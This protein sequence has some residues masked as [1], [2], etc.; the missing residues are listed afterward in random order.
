[1]HVYPWRWLVSI[2][3]VTGLLFLI[4]A[5]C[6]PVREDRSINW[7]SGGESVGFQHGQE[8][9]FIADKDTGKLIKVFQPDP[10]VLATSSPL[11][12]PVGRQLLFT[13]ARDPKGQPAVDVG[14]LQGENPAGNIYHQRD[15]IY[16]CWLCEEA[17]AEKATKPIALFEAACDHV[18]YVAANLVVRWHPQGQRILYIKQTGE[19]QHGLFE[20]DLE[21]KQSRQVLPHSSQDLIFDWTPDGTH[22]V[23]VLGSAKEPQETDGI[24]I[25]RPGDDDWWQVPNSGQFAKAELSSVLEQLRATR[26]AWTADGTRFAFA[27]YVP[28]MTKEEPGRHT[29][30]FG[31]LANQQ[32]EELV[33][34]DQPYRELH[35]SPDNKQLGMLRGEQ[36]AALHLLP[37]G[38]PLSQPINN[39]PVRRFAG[40]NKDGSH[41]AY[42]VPDGS[43][44]DEDDMWAFLLVPDI[45][46]RDA[47]YITD[48]TG[49]TPG[50]QVFSGLRVTFPQWSPKDDK[51]SLWVTFSPAYRSLVSHLLGWGLRRGDPAAIFDLKTREMSWMAVNAQEKIQIGHYHLLKH[52]YA[53]AWRWYEE[54]ERELPP[55]K[56]ATPREFLEALQSLSGPRDFSFFQYHCLTKLER[57]DDA[58]RKLE[59]FQ[60]NF[61]PKLPEA[62]PQ[63]G[64]TKQSSAPAQEEI[65]TE[66][67]MRELLDPSG[68]FSQLLRD[69]YMAEVFLS[70]DAAADGEAFFRQS[71]AAADTDQARLSHALVLGEMLLLQKKHAAYAELATDKITP[72][73]FQFSKPQSAD[74]RRNLIDPQ[75]LLDMVGM[76]TLM[77]LATPDFLAGLPAEQVQKLLPSWHALREKATS[78]FGRLQVDLVL[79]ASYQRLGMEKEQREIIQRVRDNPTDAMELPNRDDMNKAIGTVRKEIRGMFRLR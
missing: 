39:K 19:Q 70:V 47:V 9:V 66:R 4:V 44:V 16:T 38:K 59:Q 77:P 52:D 76:F 65:A 57:P 33:Q 21:S 13:T 68:V 69:L 79:H 35:W 63:A 1:M 53:Q 40:W 51:L 3:A 6:G 46:A 36:D 58:R 74:R 67:L 43:V 42:V 37:L 24:W 49:A 34:G 45:E 72:L 2:V 25:G 31:T 64:T 17:S 8:G 75:G 78:D 15:I 22:L 73:L 62:P 12:S 30:W 20:Y 71:L 7:S 11:W 56:A 50:Q 10:D 26:P 54:A 18:G 29:L 27:S 61:L 28:G 14:I 41:L 55:P 32:M 48:R 23:C 5:G 60:Q